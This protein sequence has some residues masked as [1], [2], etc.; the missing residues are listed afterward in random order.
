NGLSYIVCLSIETFF[1]LAYLSN[2]LDEYN[3][4]TMDWK[5]LSFLYEYLYLADRCRSAGKL[6]S[7]FL[8]KLVAL[9]L[10][11]PSNI[12]MI[13]HNLGAH[14]LGFCGAKFYKL[15][16]MKIGRITGLNPKG[17]ISIYPW[18]TFYYL[19][20]TLK[21]TDAEFVDLIHTAKA[22]IFPNTTGHVE[23]YP[24]RGETPQPGCIHV[25]FE[26]DPFDKEIIECYQS[27]FYLKLLP[28]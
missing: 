18:E 27:Q 15:T 8:T 10:I 25:N 11:M 28:F 9:R 17:P 19:Q 4:I 20:R 7:Y 14:T 5:E 24:N 21:K 13:G 23:F 26:R 6:L 1:A 3:I 12:H 16:K 2:Y 22:E